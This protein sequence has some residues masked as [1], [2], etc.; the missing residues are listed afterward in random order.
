MARGMELFT[1][2]F[3]LY[4]EGCTVAR[5]LLRRSGAGAARA[6]ASAMMW[7]LNRLGRSARGAG[8]TRGGARRKLHFYT[9]PVGSVTIA[10]A[11]RTAP[12][13]GSLR[14]SWRHWAR[15]GTHAGC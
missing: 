2:D 6:C 1:N 7:P 11:G 13:L 15:T 4:D 14:P 8:R 12:R 9:T 10:R 5:E 3:S